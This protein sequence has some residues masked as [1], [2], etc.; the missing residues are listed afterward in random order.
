[1]RVIAKPT[2]PDPTVTVDS[3]AVFYSVNNGAYNQ[4]SMTHDGTDTIFIGTIPKQADGSLV[5]YFFTAWQDTGAFQGIT[6]DTLFYY[7]KS[8]GY[9]IR[10]IQYTPFRD[11]MSGVTDLPLAV[12]G[13]VQADTSIY[14]PEIDRTSN[15]KKGETPMVFMQDGTG[16][17]SGIL[18]YDSLAQMLHEGDSVFVSGTA[19][20]YNDWTEI[21]VDSTH[22]FQTGLALYPAVKVKTG[23]L[24]NKPSGDP[25]A[26]QWESMLVEFDSVYITNNDPDNGIANP[27]GSYREYVVDDG[28]GGCRVDD[29]GTNTYSVDPHDASIG[30]TILKDSTFIG[31]LTGTV[32]YTHSNY[33]IEPRTNSDFKDIVMGIRRVSSPLPVKFTLEQNYPNPFNPTTTLRY[34]IPRASMV[35]MKIY[36]VLG[37]EVATLVSQRQSAGTYTVTFEASRFASGVYFYRLTAGSYSSVKKMML[38]K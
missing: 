6:P 8:N 24:G 34:S 9:T 36:N 13:R 4:V 37:Q 14:P 35:T 11:G 31:S 23:T 19:T 16:P 26:E 32:V 29:D 30:F 21:K 18:L 20:E 22:V 5:R 28:S 27:N 12:R 1:M 7:V 17:W 38:L 15:S 2:G 33:K 3:A 10:D 25:S